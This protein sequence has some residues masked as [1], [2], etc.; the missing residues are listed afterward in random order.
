MLKTHDLKIG[1]EIDLICFHHYGF[2]RGSV[3]A[4]L[5]ANPEKLHLFDDL[6]QVIALEQ[7][8]SIVLP[9]IPEPV[10][11]RIPQRLFN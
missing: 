2:C 1:D 10:I 4:V 7:R 3:E 5:R 11:T 6:G 8:E 9:D